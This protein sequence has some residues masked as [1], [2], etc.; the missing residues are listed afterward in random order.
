MSRSLTASLRG[1]MYAQDTDDV[2]LVLLTLSHPS[3]SPPIRVVSNTEDV[4]SRGE[5][6]VAYPF[7]IV[8]PDE[9]DRSLPRATLS[10]DN[11]SKEI[12]QAIRLIDSPVVVTIEAV[13][14]EDPDTV[15]VAFS[16]FLL[17][18]VRVDAGS[19][20]GELEME[21]LSR[22]PYPSGHFTPAEFPGLF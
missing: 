10:I 8:M 19:V 9:Q 1:A 16:N 4:V 18:S 2:F 7:D 20:S 22:E 12:G 5:T 17:R 15:E 21:D 3:F 6:F 11:V 14:A 13:R